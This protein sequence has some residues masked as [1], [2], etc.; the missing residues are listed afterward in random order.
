MK[1]LRTDWQGVQDVRSALDAR[2]GSILDRLLDL[3]G[4]FERVEEALPEWANAIYAEL[5]NLVYDVM[6]ISGLDPD[7]PEAQPGSSILPDEP[8]F[9]VR[10]K[11]KAARG[12]VI[13]YAQL[14]AMEGAEP[15]Y[16]V[17]IK[18]WAD[19]MA[20]YRDAKLA[21]GEWVEHPPNAPELLPWPDERRPSDAVT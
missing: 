18:G 14:A 13:C 19:E 9:M 15:E 20:A 1:H 10:A 12:T 11:T 21:S 7:K 6:L 4:H 17:R 5:Q 8:V 16:C 3:E 2:P